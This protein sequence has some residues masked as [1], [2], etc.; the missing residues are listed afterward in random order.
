MGFFFNSLWK[1]SWLLQEDSKVSLKKKKKS[2]P[3]V[4]DRKR[5]FLHADYS[6]NVWVLHSI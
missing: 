6:I 1:Q 4:K 3:I 5:R 2:E